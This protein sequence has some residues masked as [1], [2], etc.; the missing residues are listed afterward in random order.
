MSDN[1]L[2]LSEQC[3]FREWMPQPFYSAYREVFKTKNK[4]HNLFIVYSWLTSLQ[5]PPVTHRS[6]SDLFLMTH[7]TP[8]PATPLPHHHFPPEL[9]IQET[10]RNWSY[11]LP[12]PSTCHQNKA[13]L[14]ATVLDLTCFKY[15]CILSFLGEGPSDRV[16]Q[17]KYPPKL[18]PPISPPQAGIRSSPHWYC[19]IS[20][21]D[22]SVLLKRPWVLGSGNWVLF[23]AFFFFLHVVSLAPSMLLNKYL[24]YLFV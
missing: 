19:H 20:S 22:G 1:R 16:I 3:C 7:K 17:L 5:K 14:S 9:C 21:F 15:L 18:P 6:T 2:L 24:I 8:N 13:V 23:F 12:P 11:L 4:Q 10:P